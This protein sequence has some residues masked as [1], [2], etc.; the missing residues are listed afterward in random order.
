MFF[1]VTSSPPAFSTTVMY[2]STTEITVTQG[3]DEYALQYAFSLQ[4]D[5]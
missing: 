5:C 4:V 1:L 3:V 2:R